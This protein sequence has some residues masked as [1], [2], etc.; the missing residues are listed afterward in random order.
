MLEGQ[1]ILANYTELSRGAAAQKIVPASDYQ[2]NLT[3]ELLF[4]F[5]DARAYAEGADA[6]EAGDAGEL[7]PPTQDIVGIFWNDTN[8]DGVQ[9]LEE[10][11]DEYGINGRRVTLERYLPDGQ[12]GWERDPQWADSTRYDLNGADW[13]AYDASPGHGVGAT[14]RST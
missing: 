12:G 1:I 6:L 8:N 14:T 11:D 7:P 2:N 9:S 4:D 5:M 13:D 3:G 10:G